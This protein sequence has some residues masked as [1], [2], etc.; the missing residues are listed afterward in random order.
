MSIYTFNLILNGNSNMSSGARAS[1]QQASQVKINI[2]PV[3]AAPNLYVRVKGALQEVPPDFTVATD[4]WEYVA[5]VDNDSANLISGSTGV[6]VNQTRPLSLVVAG[7]TF[8]WF[9][10]EIFNYVSG[11][12]NITATVVQ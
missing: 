8:Y 7:G 5:V 3:G 11:T 12:V 6:I 10:V 4:N 2:T 1:G 9:T